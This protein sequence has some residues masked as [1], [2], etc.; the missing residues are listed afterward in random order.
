MKEKIHDYNFTVEL[1]K[2]KENI[3]SDALSRSPAENN[4]Q[5]GEEIC[6]R[7]VI[8]YETT[9]PNLKEVEQYA[10][11]DPDYQLLMK[12][13]E[14]GFSS[15]LKKDLRFCQTVSPTAAALIP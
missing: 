4:E 1:I 3:I 12:C 10:G 7:S 13:I 8:H 2:G 9:D 11:D 14:E 6:V 5:N 15:N